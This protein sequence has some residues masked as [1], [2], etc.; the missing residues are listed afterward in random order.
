MSDS[1]EVAAGGQQKEEGVEEKETEMKEGEK[2]IQGE[3]EAEA[4][5]ATEEEVFRF[6]HQTVLSSTRPRL[7][8]FPAFSAHK[9]KPFL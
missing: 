3:K 9:T 8:H 5:E 4:K 7:Q 1:E 6:R 2:Q